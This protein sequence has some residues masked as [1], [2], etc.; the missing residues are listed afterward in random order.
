MSVPVVLDAS[1]LVK[2]QKAEPGSEAALD[3]L[4]RHAR[5]EV[6]IH[7]PEH[8][9]TEDLAVVTRRLECG[10]AIDA[11]VQLDMAGIAAHPLDDRIV[12]EAEEQMRVLGC[13][14]YDA[15]APALAALLGAT[16]YS[17]DAKAHAAFPDV[18]LI[19]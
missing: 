3:L 10:R 6:D 14:F 11:W 12:R 2:A 5:G 13:D 17:A 15:L 9:V 16:L 19:G 7:V 1:V 18:R 8:C 4:I